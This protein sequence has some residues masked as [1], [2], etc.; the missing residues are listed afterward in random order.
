MPSH[1]AAALG[2]CRDGAWANTISL[3]QV[4]RE[5]WHGHGSGV[6]RTVVRFRRLP[7]PRMQKTVFLVAAD[8]PQWLD[9][10]DTLFGPTLGSVQFY[11]P[12]SPG[13][14]LRPA[15]ARCC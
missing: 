14:P 1:H 11:P 7:P 3:P 10:L 13:Y 9:T 6:A 15:R 4:L 5:Y 8:L 2:C 12:P